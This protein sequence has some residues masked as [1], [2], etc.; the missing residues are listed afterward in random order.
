MDTH[1]Y[2]SH[3]TEHGRV[4]YLPNATTD[5]DAEVID[6]EIVDDTP[7]DTTTGERAGERAAERSPG[8]ELEDVRAR[9]V[10]GHRRL[11]SV[12]RRDRMAD[13]AV[14]LTE[15]ATPVVKTGSKA[16]VRNTVHVAQGVIVVAKRWRDAHGS[17]RYER[18]MRAAEAAGDQEALRYWQEAA[19][20]EKQARHSRVMDWIRSPIEL[21]KAFAIGVAGVCGFLL[22]VGIVL[23]VADGDAGMI[24]APIGLVIDTVR[25]LWWFGA[26]YGFLLFNAALAALVIYLWHEG[27]HHASWTPAWLTGSSDDNTG[28]SVLVT[29]GGIVAA[30]Q[31]LGIAPLN[32]AFKDG[33]TPRFHL[34]PTREGQGAFKGFR[35]IFDLPMGVTPNMI[36]D[37]GD[38]L[39]ANLSRNPV[40]VWPSD[41]G[42][43]QGGRPGCVNLYVADAGVMD[44]PT[45]EYPLLHTGTADVFAGVPMGITQRGDQVAFPLVGSNVVFGGQP[46]Q[47]KSNAGR[48]MMLGAALDPLAELRVHV[49]ALNGDFDVYAPRLSRYEKGASSEHVEA[50]VAHLHELY[51][52]V[53]RREGRLAEIGAKKLTRPIADKHPDMRPL[54]VV[55]SECHELFGHAE[56]GK[57]AAELA[58]NVVKRGRK[59]GVVTGYDTQSSRT[60]AIP[61]QL[62]ENV[63][64][65][66]CF[67]VKTWRSNDGFL[68]DGSF[69]A[70]I[71][72]TELRFNI[73]R[74]TMV[75]TGATDELF[76]ICRTYFIDVDDDAGWD[77]A[78]D[79]ITRAM[80]A[81]APGTPVEGDRPQRQIEQDRD[82]LEDLDAVLGDEPVPA[83][84]VPALLARHAPGWAP[85][86]RLTGKALRQQLHADYGIKVP[87]TGNR[88]PV[89]PLTVRDVLARQAT[90]DLDTDT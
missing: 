32:R 58:I 60:D 55:F 82:L 63:G 52:E 77:Q 70:G 48:V 28:E 62:V 80:H 88:W 41:Y 6:A 76:E 49:F 57:E 50:A 72:A 81:L 84:D 16:L 42:K 73:D 56:H 12:E 1:N 33:W 36:S 38:V 24:L 27:K 22:A 78:A 15:R 39:A 54:I 46:G 45:P 13:G 4:V 43:E 7:T 85:Y 44:K 51:E 79:V 26:A 10:F 30:L 90:A 67:S 86:R 25:W 69:A 87:S 59:T 35:A 53:T 17:T 2:E 61:S 18:Q 71:R 19:V 40:E 83:A 29:P 31:H 68:G 75:V 23:A 65:N 74:G 8:T 34:S 21:A 47:G 66:G 9:T 3:D 11:I 64:L 37:K 5:A 89:D 20:A 14:V